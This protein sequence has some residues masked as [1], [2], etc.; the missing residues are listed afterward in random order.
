MELIVVLAVI[1]VFYRAL[2]WEMQGGWEELGS[3][4]TSGST[5]TRR[6][7]F[8]TRHNLTERQPLSTFEER[9]ATGMLREDSEVWVTA[10]CDGSEAVTATAT[11]GTAGQCKPSDDPNR[12]PQK[13]GRLGA[14]EIRIYHNHLGGWSKSVP[15]DRDKQTHREFK[16]FLQM[17]GIRCRSFLVYPTLTGYDIREYGD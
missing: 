15:S 5:G 13:C 4:G 17:H 14:D 10:F 7:P 2:K 3:S 12:W 11:V 16:S 8:K 9:M 1:Y 6:R